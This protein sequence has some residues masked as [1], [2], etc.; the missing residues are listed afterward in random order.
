VRIAIT[1]RPKNDGNDFG[2]DYRSRFVSASSVSQPAD[3]MESLHW[4]DMPLDTLGGDLTQTK[5]ALADAQDDLVKEVFLMTSF[6]DVENFSILVQ[7]SKIVVEQLNA[8]ETTTLTRWV[9]Y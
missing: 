4:F 6:S 8:G 3:D 1:T 2:A 5:V 9:N 7:E